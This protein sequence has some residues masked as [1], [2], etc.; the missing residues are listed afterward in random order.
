MNIQEI[1]ES[2]KITE[3]FSE[4]SAE[5]MEDII[6]AS[7]I[8]HYERLTNIITRGEMDDRLC[9]IISGEVD[10]YVYET[11]DEIKIIQTLKKGDYFGEIALLV[12]SIRSASARC[13]TTCE[14]CWIKKS[15]FEIYLDKYPTLCRKMLNLVSARLANTLHII[16]EKKITCILMNYADENLK[17]VE[18]F[19]DYFEK[20]APCRVF[21][22]NVDE[23]DEFIE[24]QNHI[25]AYCLIRNKIGCYTNIKY[26]I[27]ITINFTTGET[28]GNSLSHKSSRWEIEHTIRKILKKTIGIALASGGAPGLAHIGVLNTLRDNNIPI[29]YI[30]GTSAGALYGAMFAF[31]LEYE[32]LLTRLRKEVQR[33]KLL[34]A[35]MN[36]SMNFTGIMKTNH[37]RK[38]IKP[39][40]DNYNLED[41]KIPISTVASDLYTGKTVTINNGNVIDA[42]L[43]SNAAPLLVEPFKMDPYLLVDGVATSPLPVSTLAENNI[44]IKVAVKIPQLDLAVKMK[45]NPK[46]LSIYLRTR[47]MMANQMV[48]S[49]AHMA[50]IVIQPAV[51]SSHLMD[52][53]DI[54]KYIDAGAEAA[55]STCNHLNSLLYRTSETKG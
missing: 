3:I 11:N 15:V 39:I 12:D 31:D 23:L 18:Y 5:D 16:S 2:F 29:D 4:I 33:P 38:M 6:N 14:I 54:Q 27:D 19:E 13:K 53:D 52:W 49:A 22:L 30:A 42:I 28:T 40:F 10:V 32:N 1:I 47:S 36:L 46:I 48:T 41:A 9:I 25:K 34:T 55:Q 7:E 50:D 44:D 51:E 20:I 8:S 26:T 24:K 45:K 37:L 21:K 35:L 43:A 17:T